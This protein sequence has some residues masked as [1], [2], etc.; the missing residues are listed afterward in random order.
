MQSLPQ[1][2]NPWCPRLAASPRLNDFLESW[3]ISMCPNHL[4]VGG[5]SLFPLNYKSS[6]GQ[7]PYL[8]CS[9]LNPCYLLSCLAHRHRL[10]V[11]WIIANVEVIYFLKN[12]VHHP[13]KALQQKP[14][15]HVNQRS[16]SRLHKSKLCMMNWSNLTE[17][18]ELTQHVNPNH[19]RLFNLSAD[20]L[21]IFLYILHSCNPCV[22]TILILLF[23]NSHT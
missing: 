15:H 2:N 10:F 6:G 16:M 20:F 11:E 5:V 4:I 18:K 7:A 19:G 9:P 14:K 1:G 23:L 22:S 13:P 12:T 21:E 17:N 8:I 3:I